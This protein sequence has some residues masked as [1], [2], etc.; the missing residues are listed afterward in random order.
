MNFEEHVAKAKVLAP[1]SVPVPRGKLCVTPDEA[2]G[3][4]RRDRAMRGQGAGAGRQ[5]RQGGRHS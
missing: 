4:F 2:E 1:A 5:T 3:R